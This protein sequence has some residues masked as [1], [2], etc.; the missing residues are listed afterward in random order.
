[1]G[2]ALMI[3]IALAPT[4]LFKKAPAPVPSAATTG[5]AGGQGGGDSVA[6]RQRGSDTGSR[7]VPGAAPATVQQPTGSNPP[8][9]PPAPPED[10]V[11]V[12]SALYRYSFS[13]R[14]GRLIGATLLKY[15]STVKADAA[16]PLE[17]IGTDASLFGLVEQ[18]GVD[19]LRVAD[20]PL[21]PSATALDVTTAIQTLTF[22]GSQGNKSVTV[23]Y[24]FHPDDYRIEVSGKL[25]GVGPAGGLLLVGLGHGLRNTE[26]DTASN[27]NEYG[28]VVRQQESKVTKLSS[29]DP[30]ETKVFAG[31]FQWVALKSKYF[32]TSIMSADSTNPLAGVTATSQAPA[33]GE[34]KSFRADTRVSMALASDGRFGYTGYVGPM[35]FKRLKALGRDFDDVNPYGWPG[36]RVVIRFFT[37]PVRWLLVAMHQ[38]L[39]LTYG[40]VLI[41]FGVLI[42]GLT[43]PL[44]AKAMR[45]SM[46]MQELQPVLKA[47]QA[48]YSNDPTA[49]NREMMALYKEKGVNPL[50][51]CLPMMIPMPVLWALFVVFQYSIE[52]RGT[53]FLWL[54]DLSAHDPLYIIPL[55]MGVSM[56]AVSKIGQ[57]GLPPN[58]QMASMVYVMPVAMTLLFSRFPAGLNLYYAVQNLAG[59]PQQWM[60]TQE[61]LKRSAKPVVVVNT[62]KK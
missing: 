10:T 43:W 3:V 28:I 18:G 33:P 23:S 5:G 48:K 13:S 7:P 42:K 9:G 54:T 24:Q 45:S 26:A 19:S 22:T 40:V 37:T 21:T 8:P 46:K 2:V 58:P 44:Q 39:G 14:G 34:K 17:I 52:L 57:K 41:L 56:F 20:W 32:T 61:R 15:H 30:T 12:S 47:L 60:L 50:G 49:L 62:K 38:Y 36:F 59:L 4:F 53:P 1:L 51:G 16:V 25:D 31:P 11:V 6:G 29:F 35:E 27:H 55:I